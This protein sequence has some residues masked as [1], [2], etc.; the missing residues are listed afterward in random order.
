MTRPTVAS[1]QSERR[2]Y[3]Q[4]TQEELVVA[5]EQKLED[6]RTI[7]QGVE[8]RLAD[9]DASSDRLAALDDGVA[10]VAQRILEIKTTLDPSWVED[11][12]PLIQRANDLQRQRIAARHD[13]R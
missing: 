11:R 2:S 13:V 8:E 5:M 4:V 6:Y 12:D 3:I 7:L 9:G 10:D 1:V